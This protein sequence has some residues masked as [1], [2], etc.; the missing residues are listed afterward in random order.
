MQGKQ[1]GGRAKAEAARGRR[2]KGRLRRLAVTN[3]DRGGLGTALWREARIKLCLFSQDRLDILSGMRFACDVSGV[4]EQGYRM[5]YGRPQVIVFLMARKQDA[6][7]WTKN[8][9]RRG[10]VV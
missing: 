1:D 9:R 7:I 3:R 4:A 8:Q 10:L 2:L 5:L 6:C